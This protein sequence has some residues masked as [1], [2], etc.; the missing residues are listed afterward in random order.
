[1][2][3]ASRLPSQLK[4]YLPLP[5]MQTEPT[6]SASVAPLPP[7]VCQLLADTRQRAR[8]DAVLA[9]ILRL[10]ALVGIFFWLTTLV[11]SGWFALQKLELPVGLRAILLAFVLPAICYL[12]ATLVVG[13]AIRRIPDLDLAL[14]L[15]RRFPQFRDRL[16][17]SVEAQHSFAADGP[18]TTEMLSRTIRETGN[19]AASVSAADV[20]NAR[21]IKRRGAITGGLAL[22]ILIGAIVS[23]GMLS[24]WWDAFVR[25]EESYHQRTTL[26]EVTVIAQPGDRRREFLQR[27]DQP[28]YLH[29]RGADLELEMS[30]P[31][32]DTATG[33]DWIVPER[34][35]IDIT[36]ADGSLSR[37]YLSRT[38]DR[39]F[40]FVI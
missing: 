33:R 37:T 34:V 8:R 16:V 12:L 13:P 19:L 27:D 1:M 4:S 39:T 28:Y 23:P 3:D 32:T 25:C 18:L 11:D 26:L 21:A 2:G 15:E 35:R 17:T 20:F 14:L 24:R 5:H 36:R 40:R 29:P 30:V 31:E 6:N 22:S 10:A 9:G 7:T 38:S